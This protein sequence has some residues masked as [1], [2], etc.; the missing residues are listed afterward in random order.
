MGQALIDKSPAYFDRT[1]NEAMALLVEARDYAQAACDSRSRPAPDHALAVNREAF[2]LTTRLT[3]I[4]SWLLAHRALLNH[5][6]TP[7]QFAAPDWRLNAQE[8]CHDDSGHDQ[9]A[10]PPRLRGL[11]G[12]S[13][14]LYVRISHLDEASARER[15]RAAAPNAGKA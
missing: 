2:R 14:S 9:D 5:E 1:Y 11:L 15:L 4:M 8:I 10:I 13:H 3:Q 12:R 7:G 6:L